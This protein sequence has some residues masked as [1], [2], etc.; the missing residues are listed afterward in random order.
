MDKQHQHQKQH[1]KEQYGLSSSRPL[2]AFKHNPKA[3][4]TTARLLLNEFK[5][6]TVFNFNSRQHDVTRDHDMYMLLADIK[7][8]SAVNQTLFLVQEFEYLFPETRKYAFVISIIREPCDHF[9]SLWSF[10][11]SEAGGLYS[12][13]KRQDPEWTKLAYGQDAPL[14]DSERDID[15][16]RNVW[17]KRY[18]TEI[19]GRFMKYYGHKPE[20]ILEK[21]DCWIYLDNYKATF[22]SCLKEYENQGGYVNWTAPMLANLT[23]DVQQQYAKEDE[24]QRIRKLSE[25]THM[26]YVTKD[27]LE[28]NQ[29]SHHSKCSKYYDDS[30]ADAVRNDRRNCIIFD[31]FGYEGC[32]GKRVPK[33]TTPL[34]RPPP[35]ESSNGEVIYGDR[36][37]SDNLVDGM[38]DSKSR[39]NKNSTE[40]LKSDIGKNTTDIMKMDRK[41]NETNNFS[42]IEAKSLPESQHLHAFNSTTDDN[43]I[44]D[45]ETKMDNFFANQNY[46]MIIFMLVGASLL[47]FLAIARRLISK[48]K[49]NVTYEAVNADENNDAENESMDF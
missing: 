37:N 28:N 41:K 32:C 43:F 30:L 47:M 22:Y 33:S 6:K 2:L 39:E 25:E 40:E 24:E 16:F 19:G 46:L 48:R 14:F 31:L 17:M 8:K 45:S 13:N 18:K 10:G 4:G 29:M 7:T 20:G 35:L 42:M 11:S 34:I 12:E 21:V 26:E 23:R 49:K 3:G 36:D 38:I 5:P 9:I 1:R 15:S 44:S 27:S